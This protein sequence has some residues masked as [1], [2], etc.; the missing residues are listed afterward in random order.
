MRAGAGRAGKLL[1]S[2]AGQVRGFHQALCLRG[3]V[4]LHPL[5]LGT[6]L[7]TFLRDK[8]VG[9]RSQMFQGVLNKGDNIGLGM[10]ERGAMKGIGSLVQWFI[11]LIIQVPEKE[12]I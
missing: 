6:E 11:L 7:Q 2:G 5:A 12:H 8:G 10:G 3:R 1:P 9:E 4:I